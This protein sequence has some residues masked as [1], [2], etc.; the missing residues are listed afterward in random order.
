MFA[1]DALINEILA[2]DALI[3]EI[4]AFDEFIFKLSII[5]LT[6]AV[7]AT[8]LVFVGVNDNVLYKLLIYAVDELMTETFAVDAFKIL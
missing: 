2:V 3:K 5:Y 7:V 1:L 4:F 8:W 6:Y